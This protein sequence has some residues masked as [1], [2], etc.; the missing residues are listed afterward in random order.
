MRSTH[1]PGRGFLGLC[2]DRGAVEKGAVLHP[3]ATS[4]EDICQSLFHTLVFHWL[5]QSSGRVQRPAS[6]HALDPLRPNLANLAGCSIIGCETATDIPRATDPALSPH[7]PE[8][9]TKPWASS[10]LHCLVRLG[11]IEHHR[12]SR[13]CVFVHDMTLKIRKSYMLGSPSHSPARQFLPTRLS[14]AII[15]QSYYYSTTEQVLSSSSYIWPPF[16]PYLQQIC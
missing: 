2:M 3:S 13:C 1:R 5:P 7:A 4:G 14:T 6:Q 11:L 15:P 10:E 8:Y 12:R 9:L 16:P